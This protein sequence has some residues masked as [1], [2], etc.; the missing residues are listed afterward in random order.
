MPVYAAD[1][2]E[3]FVD[4][5]AINKAGDVADFICLESLSI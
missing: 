3:V 5:A 1:P 2:Y 4:S